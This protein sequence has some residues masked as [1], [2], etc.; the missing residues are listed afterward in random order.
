MVEKYVDPEA[1]KFPFTLTWITIVNLF[2]VQS[3]GN[4]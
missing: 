4:C 1:I 3:V 2:V